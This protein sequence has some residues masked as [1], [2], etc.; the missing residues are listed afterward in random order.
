MNKRPAALLALYGSVATLKAIGNISSIA[1]LVQTLNY[2]QHVTTTVKTLYAAMA[3]G[4]IG[5]AGLALAIP[6]VLDL[7]FKY[8]EWVWERVQ[9]FENAKGIWADLGQFG[10]NLSKGEL[11]ELVLSAK[12][13]YLDE[14]CDPGLKNSLEIQLRRLYSDIDAA[15]I[16]LAGQDPIHLFGRAIF[17]IS[18]ERRA[19]ELNKSLEAHKNSLAQTLAISDIRARRLPDGLLL[20]NQR[21]RNYESFGYQAIPFTTGLFVARGDYRDQPLEG[22]YREVTVIIERENTYDQVPEDIL[23]EIASFLH[24]RL[25]DKITLPSAEITLQTLIAADQG[26]VQHPLDFRFRLA[27]RLS[28]AI[29]RVHAANLVHKNIRTETILVLL[30][31]KP[32]LDED[33]QNITGFG[34]VYLTNWR[35]LRDVDGPTIQSGGDQWTED[36]YRHPKRQGLQVQER[37]NMGHDIYS[38]GVCL[39]EIGLWDPLIQVRTADGS[40]KVSQQFRAAAKVESYDNPEVELRKKLDRPTEVKNILLQLAK[41]ILPPKMGLGYYRLVAAC[42]TGLDQP[43]GFGPTVNFTNMNVVEQGVAFKELFFIIRFLLFL[44]TIRAATEFVPEFANLKD[45]AKDLRDVLFLIQEKEIESALE[46]FANKLVKDFAALERNTGVDLSTPMTSV[47]SRINKNVRGIAKT[48]KNAKASVGTQPTKPG[49]GATNQ[50]V[51]TLQ[52]H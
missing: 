1:Q 9:T 17:T 25:P 28:E 30:P 40:P 52:R 15:R 45:L 41:D 5:A 47:F 46:Q 37:Y 24:Y 23:K 29:L 39:L 13:F 31:S 21:F 10:W 7:L 27:R 49:G 51:T 6:G 14:G 3:D 44:S 22:P 36:L 42:L 20:N 48:P 26:R 12:S 16:F 32:A 34:D 4:G 33:G 2:Y 18:G 11:H 43:S 35:L 19:K 50:G 38:L 8:G